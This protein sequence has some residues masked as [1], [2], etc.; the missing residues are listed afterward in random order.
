M[1]QTTT[2]PTE[3]PWWGILELTD[4]RRLA[5]FLQEVEMAGS[6]VLRVDI[7]REGD[8]HCLTQFY[9]SQAIYCIT[10]C[11]KPTAL[12]LTTLMED[13]E[14]LAPWEMSPAAPMPPYDD[15]MFG[16]NDLPDTE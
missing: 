9:T 7:Y 3:L 16:L 15:E 4:R 12:E 11:T 13:P 5:G 8:S 14:P 2:V 6:R 1:N 10:P